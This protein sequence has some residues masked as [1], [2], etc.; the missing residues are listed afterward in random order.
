MVVA[1]VDPALVGTDVLDAI[2][3]GLGNL[4]IGKVVH[5]NTRRVPPGSYSAAPFA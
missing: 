4:R 5:S 3:N 2:G 1:D